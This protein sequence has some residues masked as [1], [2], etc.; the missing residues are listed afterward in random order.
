MVKLN[1]YSKYNN[2]GKGV[3]ADMLQRGITHDKMVKMSQVS[4][5]HLVQLLSNRGWKMSHSSKSECQVWQKIELRKFH[6]VTV[7]FDKTQEDYDE[8]MTNAVYSVYLH[9]G[10]GLNILLG[11]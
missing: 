3:I 2:V 11:K 4:P 1:Q 10:I 9:E 7:P 8:A 6:Q 5:A